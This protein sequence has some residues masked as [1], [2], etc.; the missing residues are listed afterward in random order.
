MVG[1]VGESLRDRGI[2]R[3]GDNVIEAEIRQWSGKEKP[4]TDGKSIKMLQR[5]SSGVCLIVGS[6]REHHNWGNQKWGCVWGENE[7]NFKWLYHVG[8]SG[9]YFENDLVGNISIAETIP[10]LSEM[11]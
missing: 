4:G 6:D 2:C 8:F 9:G 10:C 1:G 7:L 11:L 3:N 5:R